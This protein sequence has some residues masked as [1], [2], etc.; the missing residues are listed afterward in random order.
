[1]GFIVVAALQVRNVKLAKYHH[2][3]YGVRRQ[4]LVE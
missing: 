4:G 2:R 1:V 3:A